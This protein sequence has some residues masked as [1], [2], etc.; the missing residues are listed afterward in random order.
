[1]RYVK[2]FNESLNR[3]ELKEFCEMYLSY[4]L[5]TEHFN[6][7]VL[8]SSKD[9][10]TIFFRNNP[11]GNTFGGD[12]IFKWSDISQ[13]Y[14]PFL[15]MLD[16]NYYIESIYTYQYGK[17]SKDTGLFSHTLR[18]IERLSDETKMKSIEISVSRK[19]SFLQRARSFFKNKK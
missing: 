18:S 15:K 9:I 7:E 14:I 6:I 10:S 12:R 13:E 19:V 5:D 4:L 1:M 17:S 2:G 11:E 16:K 3:V 8:M